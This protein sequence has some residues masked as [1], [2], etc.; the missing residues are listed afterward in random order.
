MWRRCHISGTPYG[1]TLCAINNNHKISPSNMTASEIGKVVFAVAATQ[2]IADLLANRLIFKSEAYSR[3]LSSFEKA[4]LRREKTAAALAAKQVLQKAQEGNQQRTKLGKKQTQPVYSQKSAEKDAKKL[5][6]ETEEMSELA[7]E[8]ARKHTVAGF[9]T[10][11]AF[12]ILYKILAAEYAGRV[13]A[14]LPFRP[15]QLMQKVSFSGLA[16]AAGVGTSEEVHNLWLV[17]IGGPAATVPGAYSPLASEVGHASQALSFAFIY[18]LCSFSVKM[19]V[20]MIFGTKPPL[21]ADEGVNNL[22]NSQ[23]SRKMMEQFGLDPDE[24][25][26]ARESLGL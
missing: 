2:L 19:I 18:L 7:A 22:L 15:F 8:V 14:L 20:H 13:G 4:K 17:S 5:Q 12:F 23:K 25:K 11:L 26:E 24:M 1:T 10:S 3:L 9:Y 21:G 16:Y 6:R